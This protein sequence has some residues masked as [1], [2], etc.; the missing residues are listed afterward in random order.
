MYF[1]IAEHLP[2]WRILGFGLTVKSNH[3]RLLVA[4]GSTL[5]KNL[6]LLVRETLV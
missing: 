5:V 4:L 6:D 2:I 3:D 1:F